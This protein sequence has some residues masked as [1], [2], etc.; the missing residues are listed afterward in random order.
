MFAGKLGSSTWREKLEIKSNSF[1]IFNARTSK[2]IKT[3]SSF[4]LKFTVSALG[5][6]NMLKKTIFKDLTESLTCLFGT[7]L[8]RSYS[9]RFNLAE[10]VAADPG[11]K[12]EIIDKKKPS[13]SE[14][15]PSEEEAPTNTPHNLCGYQHQLSVA[16]LTAALTGPNNSGLLGMAEIRDQSTMIDMNSF[17]YKTLLRGGFNQLHNHLYEIFPFEYEPS[18]IKP[19]ATKEDNH[20]YL[21]NFPI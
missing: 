17:F 6:E 18:Q 15:T 8:A 1:I 14:V 11:P 7:H 12:A 19:K 10:V 5:F 3:N 13:K 16:S 9:E 4:F 20:G 21:N 2:D